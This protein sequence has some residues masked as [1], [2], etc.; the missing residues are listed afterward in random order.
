MKF[1]KTTL[2]IATLSALSACNQST[3]ADHADKSTTAQNTKA[4]LD[5]HPAQNSDP[6][7]QADIAKA[8]QDN[9]N[10]SGID[11]H[12]TSVVPTQMPDIYWASVDGASPVFVDKTG[13]YIVD[14]TIVELG[15]ERP[16]DITV[17][18]RSTAAQKAL[19]AVDKATMI[20][21]PA[22]DE[23]TSIYVFSD[24]T[25][26]YCQKLHDEINDINAGGITVHYLA[27]PRGDR[28]L[29]LAEAVWCSDDKKDA[30]TR[31]KKGENITTPACTNPVKDHVTLGYSLGITGTPAIFGENG[32]QLGGYLPAPELI[33]S[34][35]T[36][37]Q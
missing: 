24:P 13:K 10:A 8:L 35:I 4:P 26:H 9:L 21:F 34:A 22:K 14:G 2:L 32:V 29:P 3:P 1:L 5:N 30:I 25:C 15:G 6:N 28:P 27:W 37:K 11:V 23:K 36:N 19:S 17:K 33:K 20:T 18:I 16:V 12:V 7:H 31:A